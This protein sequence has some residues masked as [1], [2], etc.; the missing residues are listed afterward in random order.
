MAASLHEGGDSLVEVLD[1]VL[2]AGR[3]LEEGHSRDV[4]LL[5][6]ALEVTGGHLPAELAHRAVTASA[7]RA[8][9]AG[10]VLGAV[11]VGGVGLAVTL[12][13]A[14]SAD[15]VERAAAENVGLGGLELLEHLADGVNG[16]TLLLGN[17]GL[18]GQ[19]HLGTVVL[20]VRLAPG[21]LGGLEHLHLGL[22]CGHVGNAVGLGHI[23][24]E[25]LLV[26]DGLL[27]HLLII[28][29]LL[30]GDDHRANLLGG[31]GLAVELE[32]LGSR[33]GEVGVLGLDELLDEH[34]GLRDGGKVGVTDLLGLGV[35]AL[36]VLD[37]SLGSGGAALSLVV[38]VGL[39]DTV[40][41]SIL[42]HLLGGLDNLLLGVDGI[43][44]LLA[45]A[46]REPVS[47]PR[48]VSDEVTLADGR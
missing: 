3:G 35:L 10:A 30:H 19:S 48:R 39:G 22:P 46:L 33:A 17:G 43:G 7:A 15:L 25:L 8:S 20:T 47:S 36:L 11:G 18:L 42:V 16:G 14:D 12:A 26:K 40:G 28:D 6:E 31:G 21:L 2:L 29:V 1:G 34:L 44:V 13:R 41:I 4:H 23:V 5:A 27:H 45:T 9:L 32:K 37:D 38:K 24:L